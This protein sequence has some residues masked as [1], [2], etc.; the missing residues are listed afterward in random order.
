MKIKGTITRVMGTVL[1]LDRECLCSGTYICNQDEPIKK[2][3]FV[4]L[5]YKD[6][7]EKGY[8]ADVFTWDGFW[9]V[10]LERL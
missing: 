10:K 5:Q 4:T 6:K 8:V 2:S 7:M 1:T 9:M 3:S